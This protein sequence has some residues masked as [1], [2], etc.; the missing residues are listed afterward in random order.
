MLKYIVTYIK[1]IVTYIKYIVT[2]IKKINLFS[3]VR[4]VNVQKYILSTLNVM[5]VKSG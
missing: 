2:Y 3:F 5:F 4:W 1:Y